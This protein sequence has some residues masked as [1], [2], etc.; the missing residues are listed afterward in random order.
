MEQ[1]VFLNDLILRTP[2]LSYRDYDLNALPDVINDESF[3]AALFLANLTLYRLLEAKR[4]NW[5]E[6]SAKERLTVSRYYN[7]MCFRPTP[8]G[9]FAAFYTAEWGNDET[10]LVTS[11][12]RNRLHLWLD[13]EIS[14]KLAK[15][16]TDRNAEKGLY[17]L[18]PTIYLINREVR[19]V[20]TIISNKPGFEFSVESM[21]ENQLIRSLLKYIRS[22]PRTVSDLIGLICQKTGC[23]SDDAREYVD[24]MIDAQLIRSLWETNISG[25]DLLARLLHEGLV[26]D[27]PFKKDLVDLHQALNGMRSADTRVLS[28]LKERI[29]ALLL[30]ETGDERSRQVFYVG[31]EG[32]VAEGKLGAHF[33]E[34]IRGALRA[35]SF[36]VPHVRPSGLR[37]FIID[38]KARYDR[39]RVPLLQVLDPELGIGYDTASL[40]KDQADLLKDIKFNDVRTRHVL[41][42]WTPVHRLLFRK[43]CENI[44]PGSALVIDEKDLT[45]L[46]A[47]ENTVDLPASFPVMFRIFDSQVY[48]E[49]AG[50]ATANSII[51]RFTIWSEEITQIA[52]HIAELEQAATPDMIFAE[53]TQLS[54][55]H[56]DNISRRQAI[57]PFEI[58]VNAISILPGDKQLPLADL[59]LSV[60]DDEL[61][62]E[63]L[64]LNRRVMPRMSSAYNY[65]HN[66]L[67][68][69]RLL[70][71]L[72]YQDIQANL[73][74]DMEQL[75]PGMAFYPRV[76]YRGTILCLAKWYLSKQQ[77][78]YLTGGAPADFSVRLG[79]VK[80][81]LTLPDTVAITRHDQQIVFNLSD[82]LDQSFFRDC[83]R[84]AEQLLLQEY[85]I[86]AGD[87]VRQVKGKP[88]AGQFVAFLFNSNI[89]YQDKIS[90]QSLLT[91]D[92]QR[93]Y[94]LGSQWVYL[95]IY[96]HPRSVNQLL[97]RKV[98]PRLRVLGKQRLLSWFF[99]RYVDAGHHIRLRLRIKDDEL[100]TVLQQLKERLAGALHFQLVREYQA[101]TYRR[102]LERY[103]ADIIELVED[104]F[105]ASSEIILAF[106]RRSMA[107][108]FPFSYHSLAFVTICGMVEAWWGSL[109][110]QLHFLRQMSGTFYA[111]FSEDKSLRIDLDLKYR[112]I[113]K[114][115]SGLL[116]DHLYFS[117]LRIQRWAD[118]FYL[119][120]SRILAYAETFPAERKTQLLA[121][122]I[123][124]H[125]NRLFTD[126]QRNQELIVYYCLYKQKLA[127][128]A[129]SK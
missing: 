113:K 49:S 77:I 103:G 123:H 124:L 79:E 33:Q 121:D 38:F 27:S 102:E 53:I 119:K 114:E 66:G 12:N 36:L 76:S 43:W 98:L 35:L 39:Q 100:G 97:V 65:N 90:R 44:V 4:F 122:L 52:R 37:Q 58:P 15:G 26:A 83:L 95:K 16:L 47:M 101:D 88:L 82:K 20:K 34:D 86:A 56:V 87:I 67:A 57:Y 72:Q 126:K 84:G 6:L 69:F 55:H 85:P 32:K 118:L 106:I 48:L 78:A 71:D 45:D 60:R 105:C 63:S 7:R 127:E 25:K 9:A 125:L 96:C 107:K 62:L 5:S 73:N 91:A 111:E 108:D 99:I 29:T 46:K 92:V 109:D 64:S 28:Q 8:F 59:V 17:C 24:F 93:D 75:F 94:I 129:L 18:N 89:K 80:Q 2:L 50:A 41:V 128:R 3:R 120:Q 70:C 42:E 23:S 14:V 11:G 74:L 110:E 31:L 22:E 13:Q 81:L 40:D 1:Y 61:V 115:I 30:T 51:G 19:F 117:R 112:A 68:V 54:G 104:L 116:K 21:D 10:L